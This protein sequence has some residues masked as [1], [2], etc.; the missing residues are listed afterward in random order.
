MPRG[1]RGSI[2]AIGF[3]LVA[4]LSFLLGVLG[5]ALLI[6][7]QEQQKSEQTQ[8][9][10]GGDQRD[11]STANTFAP[12]PDLDKGSCYQARNHD[13]ADLC[14]QWRAAFAA[15]Q[16]ARA[17]TQSVWLNIVGMAL[18]GIGLGALLMTI[19]QGR[20]ALKRARKANRISER[21]AR[22]QLRAY[23][24]PMNAELL[25]VGAAKPNVIISIKNFGQTRA[26]N[27]SYKTDT[28]F[29][30]KILTD[31]DEFGASGYFGIIEPS[32]TMD[33][34]IMGSIPISHHEVDSS[35]NGPLTFYAVIYLKYSVSSGQTYLRRMSFM[36][37]HDIVVKDG[38]TLS[39]CHEG[40]DETEI[41]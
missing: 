12:Y 29:S 28:G 15:E 21:T 25:G 5:Y 40:N 1:N 26:Y 39:M 16:A 9:G 30:K 20:T 41:K 36:L 38:Y 17:A 33:L 27:V 6:D 7:G 4:A 31:V 19:A 11:T 3:G 35:I 22:R 34:S 13:T 37:E 14:A 24:G 23:I 32:D 18:S 2:L 8:Y 10:G